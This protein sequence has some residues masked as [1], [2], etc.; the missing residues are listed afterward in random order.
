MDNVNWQASAEL[1][2]IGVEDV[3]RGTLEDCVR[4]YRALPEADVRAR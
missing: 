1:R 3:T 4:A 2:R